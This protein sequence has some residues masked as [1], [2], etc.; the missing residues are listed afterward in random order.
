MEKYRY[1]FYTNAT[2]AM[3]IYPQ[4]GMTFQYEPTKGKRK[5]KG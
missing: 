5:E 3:N 2:P 1:L 4:Q